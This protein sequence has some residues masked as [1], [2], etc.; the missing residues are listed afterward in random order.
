MRI[1]GLVTVGLLMGVGLAG[2][3]QA[4]APQQQV[5]QAAPPP[6][7]ACN[8]GDKA[9]PDTH[10]TRLSYIPR[11]HRRHRYEGGGY[12][13]SYTARSEEAVQSYG[14]V[15]ASTVSYSESSEGYAGAGG[16]AREGYYRGGRH[17][18]RGGVQWVDGY[19]RGYFAGRRPTVAQSMTGKRMSVGHGYDADCPEGYGQDGY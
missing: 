8:C 14:Y 3:D 5:V 12:H 17:Y 7:P 2:C 6:A 15:S 13:G 9:V 18:Y 16:Y 11:H 19:G 4:P 1:A 10:M